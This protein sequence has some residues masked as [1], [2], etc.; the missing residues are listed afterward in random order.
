MRL[1]IYLFFLNE[2][3]F[4]L[5]LLGAA[6]LASAKLPY[7]SKELW[8]CLGDAV[9]TGTYTALASSKRFSYAIVGF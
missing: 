7:I 4:L 6:P 2:A 9:L 3:P 5:V 1:N 8:F